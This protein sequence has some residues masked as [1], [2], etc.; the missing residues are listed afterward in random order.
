MPQT[1]GGWKEAAMGPGCL[2]LLLVIGIAA[3]GGIQIRA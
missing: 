2:G 3:Y 1:E